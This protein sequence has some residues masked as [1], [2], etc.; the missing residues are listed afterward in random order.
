M[1]NSR[2]INNTLDSTQVN[3]S[4]NIFWSANYINELFNF[5]QLFQNISPGSY[6]DTARGWICMHRHGDD[7]FVTPSAYTNVSNLRHYPTS[8]GT[9]NSP[10]NTNP[11][12]HSFFE[13][14]QW[15]QSFTNTGLKHRAHQVQIMKGVSDNVFTSFEASGGSNLPSVLDQTGTYVT[16]NIK[17]SDF[18][19]FKKIGNG[20]NADYSD[21]TDEELHTTGKIQIGTH[22]QGSLGN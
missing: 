22:G 10:P 19:G 1:A 7:S 3:G 16:S 14:G 2:S 18:R 6:T 12:N 4:A 17:F 9:H 5:I 20:G 15:A 21:G 8:S 11:S 13:V